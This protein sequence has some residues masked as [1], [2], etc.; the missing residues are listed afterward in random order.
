AIDK[1][2]CSN[3][4][5]DLFKKEMSAY[6]LING[7]IVE[8]NSKE[9]IIEIETALE[10]TDKFASVNT[11]LIRAIQLYSDKR[12]PDFRNSIKESI[13][14]VEALSK[15]IVKDDKTTLGQAL[16]VIEMKHAIPKSL[17]NAFS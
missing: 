7:S 9:E 4:F 3:E 13:S 2:K 15:I 1:G 10:N 17:K 5:N 8:I 16:K 6:R 12:N 11:H 14:A